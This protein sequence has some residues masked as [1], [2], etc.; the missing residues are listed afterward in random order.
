MDVATSSTNISEYKKHE[1]KKNQ[2]WKLV[3]WGEKRQ[4]NT[5]FWK[6]ADL[7]TYYLIDF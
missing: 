7:G 5:N 2:G 1:C 6:F 4:T 3:L